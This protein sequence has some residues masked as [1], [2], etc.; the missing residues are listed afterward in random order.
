MNKETRNLIYRKALE[1]YQEDIEQN[2][3]LGGMCY[4]LAYAMD[5][6]DIKGLEIYSYSVG[7]MHNSLIEILKHKPEIFY[8]YT[9]KITN[10]E[11]FWFKRLDTES[12][13]NIL[14]NAIEETND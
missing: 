12:R 9:G 7:K 6:I 5:L 4:Y 3:M 13:I 14:T 2:K 11:E 1:L 8:D 10:L